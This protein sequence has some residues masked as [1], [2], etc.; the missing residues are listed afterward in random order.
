M[1]K[2]RLC[3]GRNLSQFLDLGHTPPADDFLVEKRLSD[4]E[5]HDP[6]QVVRCDQCNFIQLSYVVK[7]EILYQNDYPYEASSTKT[8]VAHFDEFAGDIVEKF[9]MVSED[10]AIDIGSNVGVLLASFKKRNV[11]ILGV[12]PAANIAEIANKNGIETLPEFFSEQLAQQI[13]M[14]YGKAKI[15]TGSNV[16]A[17]IDD[18]KSLTAG[19]KILLEDSG[20]FVIEAPYFVHLLHNLEYDTIYHEHLSYIS[21]SPLVSFFKSQGMDTI[22]DLDLFCKAFRNVFQN[23]SLDISKEDG[24]K[25]LDEYFVKLQQEIIDKQLFEN[26]KL[27]KESNG[28]EIIL[29]SG[30]KI[31]IIE[32]K[33]GLSP[34]LSETVTLEILI[35]DIDGNVLQEFPE[36]QTFVLSEFPVPILVEA[37]QLMS[38]GDKWNLT[39]PPELS[40]GS[41]EAVIFEVELL[42]IN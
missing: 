7:P 30:L 40:N 28:G 35:T 17:H 29:A 10:L 4:S 25:I 38:L 37:I 8:G 5:I 11:R 14:K 22:I 41:G 42:G 12:D 24:E 21:V 13:L 19:V 6:L 32:D 1:L 18:L 34:Q 36:P 20:V 2:C 39:I 15:I 26:R 33:D 3:G 16:F 23:D 9:G 31:I 27:I